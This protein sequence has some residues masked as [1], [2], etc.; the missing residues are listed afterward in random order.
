M[1]IETEYTQNISTGLE[2]IWDDFQ[3]KKF[4]V[5]PGPTHFH[6]NL[7]FFFFQ[8]PLAPHYSQQLI[9]TEFIKRLLCQ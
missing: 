3:T 7:G 9:R 4:R 5:R 8:R 2:L 1:Y 6:S